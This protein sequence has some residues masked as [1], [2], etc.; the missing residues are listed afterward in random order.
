MRDSNMYYIIMM[1]I[2]EYT[3]TN[4]YFLVIILTV[5]PNAYLIIHFVMSVYRYF[6]YDV[7]I[8]LRNMF[9]VSFLKLQ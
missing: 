9:R 6:H 8:H 1:I 2:I 7:I 5:I 4:S 3:F